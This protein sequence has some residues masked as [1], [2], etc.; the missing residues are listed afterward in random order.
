MKRHI[1]NLTYRNLM[2]VINRIMKK[3]YDFTESEKMAR[4]IFEEFSARPEGMS[5]EARIEMIQNKED[6]HEGF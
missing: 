1:R 6:Y 4:N 3:G 5:I 2:V